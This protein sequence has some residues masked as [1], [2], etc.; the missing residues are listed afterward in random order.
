MRDHSAPAATNQPRAAVVEEDIA[1]A[2]ESATKTRT[3]SGAGRN[4]DEN[5]PEENTTPVATPPEGARTVEVHEGPFKGFRGYATNEN[6]DGTV[7]A[8][9]P[10]FGRETAVTLE[11]GEFAYSS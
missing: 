7:D 8:K 1:E 5:A 2:R 10:I 4:E 3:S 11:P 6:D 9:L